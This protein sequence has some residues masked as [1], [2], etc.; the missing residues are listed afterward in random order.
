MLRKKSLRLLTLGLSLALTGS[1][2]AGCA[3]KKQT[4]QTKEQVIRYNIGAEP[5][6][7]DPTLNNSVEGGN[8]IENT[9]V[10]LFKVDDKDQPVPGMA[11]KYEVSSDGLKYTFTL[12]KDAK[13][14]DG[15]PVTA[16]DFE[17][18]WKRALNPKTAAEYAYQ[19]YYIK[20]G[21]AYN[22]SENPQ[23]TVKATEDQVGVKALDDNTLEV[24]LE[25]PTAYFLSLL[26]FPTY[27]PLRKDIVE[28]N[29]EWA[30]KPETYVSNGPFM[31]KEWKPKDTIVL[32]KNPNYFDSKNV[33]LDKLELKMVDKETTSLSAFKSGQLDITDLIPAEEKQNLLKDGSAKA[34]PYLGIYY[35]S[36]N[37][38]KEAEKVNPEAAKALKDVR[39]RKALNLAIDRTELVDKVT[40]GGEK[41]ATGYVPHGILDKNGKDFRAVD[42]LPATAKVEEAKKLLTEAGY[43]D[44]KGFPSFEIIYNDGQ[45]HKNIAQAVQE[46]WR[47]NLGIN[48]ELK[49]VER[50]VQLANLS[51]K[52]YIVSR[53]GWIADY[54]DP[55]TFLDMFVTGGGNNNP[56]Y[57]NPD[58]DKL[59]D[60]AKKETDLTKR[61]EIMAKAHEILM[62][63]LPVIPLYE[64]TN[65]SLMKNN[66]EGVHKS[67]LGFVFFEK[68][69][70]K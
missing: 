69:K 52:N 40:K 6:T 26:S 68:A 25:Y 1:L 30:T 22:N 17:Y 34:Y 31:M 62:T 10:G 35:Y 58:Y 57:N 5:K 4:T 67:P 32:A 12:R 41:A 3:G 53:T 20:N 56:G 61:N 7:V 49:S 65:V 27:M 8:I 42:Y 21:E 63:D 50:K 70:L 24:T 29:K 45:G 43:P 9:F 19:L 18:S 47:K 48:V 38:S 54:V 60:A 51:S 13:W 44:G 64:Y 2:F 23:A 59:I 46:M 36:L 11:E 33:T 28:G 15:K 66:I 39:V 37:I 16:H 14:S 55:M